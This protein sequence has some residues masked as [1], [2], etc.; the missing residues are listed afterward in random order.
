[1]ALNGHAGPDQLAIIDRNHAAWCQSQDWTRQSGRYCP[2][3]ARWIQEGRCFG[4]PPAPHDPG[5]F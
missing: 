5:D 2:Q 3:L 4:D 1:M